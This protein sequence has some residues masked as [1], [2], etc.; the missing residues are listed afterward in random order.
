M[1]KQRSMP[2][3]LAPDRRRTERLGCALPCANLRVKPWVA[4]RNLVASGSNRLL[5]FTA[6]QRA[7][8]FLLGC[9]LKQE[10]M[11]LLRQQFP[12]VLLLNQSMPRNAEIAF[13]G[14][15]PRSE[16]T[17]AANF[18]TVSEIRM[19]SSSC[20]LVLPRQRTWR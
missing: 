11:Q 3:T 17:R 7:A 12:A 10:R 14:L 18:P 6:L 13:L 4:S 16:H 9:Y 19:L 5:G 2:R 8:R 20:I 1:G 15:V